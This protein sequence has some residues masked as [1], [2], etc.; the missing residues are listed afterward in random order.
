MTAIGDFCNT[1]RG[2][3][4]LGPD[5]YPDPVVTSWVRMAEGL[6]G[7]ELRCKEMIQIDTGLLSEQRYLL[8]SDWKQL[9]LVR[10]V[11]G[12]ALRYSPKDE[13]YNT[14]Q[15]YVDDQK[16]C[17]SISGDYLIIGG[18]VPDGTEVEITYYQAPPPLEDDVVWTLKNY[19]ALFLIKTLYVAS[20]YAIEDDRGA[21]WKTHSDDMIDKANTAHLFSKASGSRL[22]RRHMRGF[23]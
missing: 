9:E 20:M 5:V 3:L 18:M 23:G 10:L 19:P 4:N 17:Y 16:H 8:P 1:I 15:R 21:T 11:G 7:D 12:G 22:T 14:N 6:L 13:F 2:W